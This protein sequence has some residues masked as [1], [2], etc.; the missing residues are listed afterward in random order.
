MRHTKT[1]LLV[2][3]VIVLTITTLSLGAKD[4]EFN[5]MLRDYIAYTFEDSEFAVHEQTLDLTLTGWGENTRMVINPTIYMGDNKTLS[6]GIREAYIDFFL[7]DADIR[8]GKQA[9]IWGEAEGA[10]IT[11]LVSPRDMRSFILADFKEIRKGV[12]AIKVDYYKDAFTF[13]GIWVAK[14]IPTSMPIK[15]SIWEKKPSLPGANQTVVDNAKF[16]PIMPE[17]TLKN[18][19]LFGKISHFGSKANWAL[20]GGYAFTDEPYITG[21]TPPS[22]PNP[23]VIDQT[24]GRYI[25]GGGS[26]ST[27]LGSTVLR[28]EAAAYFDKPFSKVTENIFPA[29]PDIDVE[30]HHQLQSLAGL[31]W[32]LWGTQMSAQYIFGYVHDHNDKLMEQ[33]KFLKEFSH[34]FTFRVQKTF[35]SDQLAAKLFTYVETDPLNAL[36]RPSLAW[37][38]EDGVVL[39]GGLDLFVG[40]KDGTFGAYKDNSLAWMALRWYF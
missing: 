17:I 10:F 19:E 8:V 38:L 23:A 16:N 3:L 22:P 36:I 32:S 37:T 4:I 30:K 27:T 28:L 25:M 1:K 34:T 2:T 39:E 20:M 24:Y 31:D 9:I 12:P 26:L 7:E 5:G 14:F 33:G 11:D 15:D 18:S 40:D 6:L 21:I 29:L 13:E 35:F